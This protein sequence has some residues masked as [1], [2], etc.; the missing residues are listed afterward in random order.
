MTEFLSTVPI[1]PAREVE[2]S[3]SWY[4]DVLGFDVFL[5]ADDYGIVGRDEA[6]IHFWGPSG[7]E[8]ESSSTSLRV[9]VRGIDQLHRE[10]EARG[11]V[12]PE[13]AP[14][15]GGVGVQGV[16]RHRSRREPRDLLRAAGRLRPAGRGH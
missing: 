7:I 6:W 2:A 14:P 10:C 12:A 8:P 15:D 4:R 5:A 11:L 13:R 1:V 9:G 16:L 3:T